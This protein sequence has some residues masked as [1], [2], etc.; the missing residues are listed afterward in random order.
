[1][2][3]GSDSF[4]RAGHE[5]TSRGPGECDW[6]ARKCRRVFIYVLSRDSDRGAEFL[7][8]RHRGGKV[9]CNLSCYRSYFS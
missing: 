4:A 5:R 7:D 3:A 9:F 2:I 8:R 6:C 1:M